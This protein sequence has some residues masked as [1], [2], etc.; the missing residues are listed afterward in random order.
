MML[1]FYIA[2]R[3]KRITRHYAKRQ[4]LYSDNLAVAAQRMRAMLADQS[5]VPLESRGV[6]H[7]VATRDDGF[8]VHYCA[9][10][11]YRYTKLNG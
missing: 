9:D 11:D 1:S 8:D 3:T 4:K 10:G 7:V 2:A 6:L 5:D